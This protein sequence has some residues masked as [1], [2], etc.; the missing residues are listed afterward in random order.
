[1]TLWVLTP[2]FGGSTAYATARLLRSDRVSERMLLP[3]IGGIVGAIIANVE[4]SILGPP[5]EAASLAVIVATHRP[6]PAVVWQGA[7]SLVLALV[8]ARWLARAVAPDIDATRRRF[9]LTLG[10]LVAFSAGGG[11]VG[12]AVGPLFPLLAT[13]PFH[14]PILVVLIGG[15][16]GLLMGSWMAAPRMIKALIQDYSEF[17]PRRSIAVLVP[18]F[19]IA[20]VSIFFGLPISFNEIFV[21]AIVGSGYAA[22]GSSVSPTN[23]L[24]TV[25]A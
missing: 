14:V 9:L 12:L 16:L 6:K 23:S 20:Q 11:K 21:S 15:G 24:Y 10:A 1:M 5:N 7:A 17:G 25:F 3:V 13:L 19:A 4:F 2:F 8:L 22:G 18:S